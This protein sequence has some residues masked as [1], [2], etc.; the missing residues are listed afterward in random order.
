MDI[1][2]TVNTGDH[3]GDI[4]RYTLAIEKGKKAWLVTPLF[5]P[6]PYMYKEQIDM[7]IA[8]REH[9]IGRS[10]A[11]ELR[12]VKKILDELSIIATETSPCSLEGLDKDTRRIRIDQDGFK[13]T[14]ELNEKGKSPEYRV[15]VTVYGL[16][17]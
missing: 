15:N 1:A 7:V 12:T 8:C 11:T 4:Y 14:T 6:P 10:G 16:Y 9:N 2:F 5:R 3:K 17:E 13:V